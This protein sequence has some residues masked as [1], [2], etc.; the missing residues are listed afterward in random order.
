[1]LR[2]ARISSLACHAYHESWM[3]YYLPLMARSGTFIRS[4]RRTFFARISIICS[5]LNK[6]WVLFCPQAHS[7]R[8]TTKKKFYSMTDS[9][10]HCIR[11]IFRPKETF[12]PFS[13]T[14]TNKAE[15]FLFCREAFLACFRDVARSKKMW[16]NDFRVTNKFPEH[17]RFWHENALSQS[18]LR[19]IFMQMSY[20]FRSLPV[21]IHREAITP[22]S[23]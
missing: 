23:N 7:T 3:Y 12:F 6:T 11:V 2:L 17:I 18:Q 5:T 10:A 8:T 22:K 4:I 16:W 13:F 14:A 21:T 15:I 19:L 1:M 20:K 9:F